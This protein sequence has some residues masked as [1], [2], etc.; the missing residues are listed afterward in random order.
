MSLRELINRYENRGGGFG[1][2]KFSWFALKD[3]GDVAVVRLL[4]KNED[5]ILKFTKEVHRNVDINGYRNTVLCLGDRCEM[6]RA[7]MNPSLR[8]WIPLY[9]V[10]KGELQFWERG[11]DD[12]K[13][14]MNLYE[15]YGDLDARDYKI[16][17]NGKKGS[18]STTYSFFPKDTSEREELDEWKAQIPNIVGRN[19]R[20]VLNLTPEQQAQVLETGTLQFGNSNSEAEQSRDEDAGEEVF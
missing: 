6:C 7:G 5:D 20:Y 17:R 13:E 1:E 15:E 16:K 14:L 18:T 2:S 12:I 4:L 9:N 3:D 19:F 10:D 11:L 8:I